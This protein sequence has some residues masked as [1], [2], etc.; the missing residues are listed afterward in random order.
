MERSDD[1]LGPDELGALIRGLVSELQGRAAARGE[2]LSAYEPP[3][4]R[5]HDVR[6]SRDEEALQRDMADRRAKFLA[7]TLAHVIPPKIF[8][9]IT[10]GKAT[11][12]EAAEFALDWW[13]A[14]RERVL[15]LRGGM[16]VGKTVAA[17]LTCKLA[18]ETGTRSISW[19]RPNDFVSGMLH[20]YDKDAP[21]IGRD[22]VVLDDM[23]RETK[24][25]FPE[26]LTTFLDNRRTRLL[27]TT[28]DLMQAWRARYDPRLV[29]RIEDE[30]IA[31]AIK[32]DSMRQRGM[33]VQ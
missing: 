8:D 15:V 29:A 21:Q 23:G 26:A 33:G 12:T 13:D 22:L 14:A 7:A 16:G 32:G 2:P 6:R 17:A 31:Y 18:M 19:H 4:G 11:K 3:S 30:G 28:N 9:L 1:R 10:G 27:I 20:A 25:D 5:H 24:P